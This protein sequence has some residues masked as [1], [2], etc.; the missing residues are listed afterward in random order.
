MSK[1]SNSGN[2]TQSQGGRGPSTHKGQGGN[3]PS[4]TGN[5]SGRGRGNALPKGK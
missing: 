5:Q 4:T 3:W 2:N 1:S